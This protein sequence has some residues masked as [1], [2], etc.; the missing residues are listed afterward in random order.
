MP[1]IETI[2]EKAERGEALSDSEQKEIMSQAHDTGGDEHDDSQL[3]KDAR[4]SAESAELSEDKNTPDGE[5]A[6][7]PEAEEKGEEP[8][9]SDE[10]DKSAAPKE[11]E[12]PEPVKEPE[13]SEENEDR[14]R[15][16]REKALYWE[17]RGERKARQELQKELDALKFKTLKQEAKA[18]A[19]EDEEDEIEDDQFLNKK[20]VE[21][22]V[23]IALQA[24]EDRHRKQMTR[25]WAREGAQAHP[26]FDEVLAIGEDLIRTN[27]GYQAQIAQAYMNGDN[28]A[29][30]VYD[31][32]KQDAKFA[33]LAKEAGLGETPTPEKKE[34]VKPAPEKKATENAKK[35]Q[36]NSKKPRTTGNEGGGEGGSADELTLEYVQGLSDAQFAALPAAK[37]AKILA[38]FG[39]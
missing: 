26:D 9:E 39:A 4:E 36:E 24:Q 11:T 14:P 17:M 34:P 37:R 29:L 3:D 35:M 32:I 21:K 10:A 38:K 25:I 30:L 22:R 16:E 19:S 15:S 5:I 23:N 31:L 2:L 7:T 8:S 18:E 12:E 13:K 28:P 27:E 20:Q 33:T 1:D 6:E